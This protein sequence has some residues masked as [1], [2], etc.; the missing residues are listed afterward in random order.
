MLTSA[1]VMLVNITN[2][3]TSGDFMKKILLCSVLFLS[4]FSALAGGGGNRWEPS[5][6][7]INCIVSYE[8]STWSW[9]NSA[10]CNE[11]IEKG[12]ASKVKYSGKYYYDDGSSMNFSVIVGP[13]QSARIEHPA[14]KKAT[15]GPR[16]WTAEWVR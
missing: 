12:Y 8:V 7:P 5:V 14:G 11:V 15:G 9:S 3:R 6:Q 2:N 13:H 10:A 4:S 16:D 1:G